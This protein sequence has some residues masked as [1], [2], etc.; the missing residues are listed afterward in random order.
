MILRRLIIEAELPAALEHALAERPLG[1][2]DFE[3][4][5][6]VAPAWNCSSQRLTTFEAREQLESGGGGFD[7]DRSRF[8]VI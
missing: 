6:S 3:P 2:K 1:E 4:W 8:T 5:L 7:V